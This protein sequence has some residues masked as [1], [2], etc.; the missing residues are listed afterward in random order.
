VETVSD[1]R[2][3]LARLFAG[4]RFDLILCDVT[5]PHLSGLELLDRLRE[6]RPDAADRLVFITGG[7]VSAE[8]QENLDGCS[9]PR[10]QKPFEAAALRELLRD[11]LEPSGS[12]PAS[13]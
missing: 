5:M 6:R 12:G 7:P 13:G 11:R 4:E 9:A 1:P 2:Q 10:L 3:A 8:V